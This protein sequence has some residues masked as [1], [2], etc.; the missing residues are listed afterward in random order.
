[1]AISLTISNSLNR[2]VDIYY[3]VPTADGSVTPMIKVSIQ[4]R[5]LCNEIFFVS[6]AHKE[7][8]LKQ[9][10]YYT[11]KGLL[12]LGKATE[13]KLISTNEKLAKEETAEKAS[14]A[15]KLNDKIAEAADNVNVDMK[16]EAV[17]E[18]SKGRKSKNK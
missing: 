7:A 16:F 2:L 14:K 11:Q 10:E 5:A 1:M 4:P 9:I 3:R 13:E 8:F 15:D 6:E 12:V 18:A 17:P